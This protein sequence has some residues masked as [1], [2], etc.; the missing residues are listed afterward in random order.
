M[1]ILG[2][3]I[4]DSTSMMRPNAEKTTTSK[5][6]SIFYVTAHAIINTVIFSKKSLAAFIEMSGAFTKNSC[7]FRRLELRDLLASHEPPIM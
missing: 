5:C 1:A 2:N 3:T 7:P 4:S 6:E